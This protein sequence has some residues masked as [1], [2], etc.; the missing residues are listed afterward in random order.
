MRRLLWMAILLFSLSSY[1]QESAANMK[2]RV[3][4]QEGLRAFRDGNYGLAQQIF[5][6]YLSQNTDAKSDL[7]IQA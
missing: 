4:Y 7:R 6:T 5:E 2:M 3:P 1:A